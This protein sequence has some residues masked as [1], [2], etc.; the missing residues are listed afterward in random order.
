LARIERSCCE[1]EALLF[2]S[3]CLLCRDAFS[4]QGEGCFGNAE[5]G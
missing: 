1:K 5:T 4:S 3:P 2:S